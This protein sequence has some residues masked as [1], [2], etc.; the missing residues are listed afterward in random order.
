MYSLFVC[1]VSPCS[2]PVLYNLSS[3]DSVVQGNVLSY[4]L[5]IRK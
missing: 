3:R 1:D 4:C 2:V 5:I